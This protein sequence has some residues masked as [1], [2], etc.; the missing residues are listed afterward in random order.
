MAERL[1]IDP[2]AGKGAA[3]AKLNP[4]KIYLENV[5]S[6]LGVSAFQ[7]K[8]YCE[9]AVR[10]GV[11]RKRVEV[12]CPDGSVAASAD[13]ES[14]LPDFVRCWQEDGGEFTQVQYATRDL[15]KVSFYQMNYDR[16]AA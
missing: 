11:F 5:R 15:R 12:V 3:I 13:D 7:A 2:L 14:G 8:L 10:R 1:R 6:V 9:T 4:E 16:A